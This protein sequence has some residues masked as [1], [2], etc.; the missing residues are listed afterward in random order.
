MELARQVADMGL[1]T[2]LPFI[3]TSPDIAS[4]ATISGPDGR[5]LNETVFHWLDPD[6]KYWKERGFALR[7]A[8]VHAARIC[9]E[10][11][12]FA[13]GRLKSWRPNPGLEAIVLGREFDAMG[14][15]TAIVAPA[16]LAGGVIGAVVWAT[17][18]RLAGVAEAYAAHAGEMHVLALKLIATYSEAAGFAA[19]A[20]ARLTR[21]EIQCLKWAAA[22]KTDREISRIVSISAPTVRFHLANAAHKLQVSGRSRAVRRAATLGY[23]GRDHR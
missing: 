22:G 14:V 16:Y 18:E 23:V 5:P 7:S 3:A 13:D 17:P 19:P 9:S 4:S 20:A 11:F 1:R 8:F 2:G 21:R 10:P 6:L 15:G 12:Y